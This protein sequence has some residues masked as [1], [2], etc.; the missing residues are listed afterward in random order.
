MYFRL[1]HTE[2]PFLRRRLSKFCRLNPLWASLHNRN[3][4]DF[5]S[6]HSLM[7]A[8]LILL[9]RTAN[10]INLRGQLLQMKWF[11]RSYQSEASSQGMDQVYLLH[12][13]TITLDVE[14]TR[15]MTQ[16]VLF[17]IYRHFFKPCLWN[18]KLSPLVSLLHTT[19]VQLCVWDVYLPYYSFP[20][21]SVSSLSPSLI[22]FIPFF[23]S[24]PFLCP[25]PL[26]FLILSPL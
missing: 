23:L 22:S 25:L 7:R 19:F 6:K 9:S 10:T 24:L 21:S 1:C 20:A 12:D 15:Y 5:C 4:E 26:S 18:Y 2:A 11:P 13:K 3:P 8:T 16:N 14:Q 17:F